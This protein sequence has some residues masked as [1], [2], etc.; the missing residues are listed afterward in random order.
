MYLWASLL[1]EPPKKFQRTGGSREEWERAS[2]KAL[3]QF[4]RHELPILVC[5]GE[6]ASK[7]DIE[8]IRFTL[9]AGLPASLEEFYRQSG[10]AGHDGKKSSC[11]LFF[12][13]DIVSSGQE[14]V[15]N[16][17]ED[18]ARN[19][20]QLDN[21][22]PG[23]VM[24]KRILSQVVLRLFVPAQIHNIGDKED[25]EI[26]I[27]SFPDGLF[28]INGE[29]KVPPERKQK[30]LEKALYR[31]LL[32]GAI[33]GYERR[34]A[35]FKVSVM[36]SEAPY[37]YKNFRN[38]INRYEL[39]GLAAPNQPNENAS[40][41][42]NAVLRFGCRLIEY[43]Y[44]RIKTR[45][46]DDKAKMLQAAKEGQISIR[47]FQDYLHESMEPS[48]IEARLAALTSE[49]RWSV[50]EEINGLD[51]LLGLLLVCHREQRRKPDDPMLRV[52]AGFCAL[53]FPDTGL[54]HNDFVNGFRDLKSSTSALCR[55]ELARQIVS[56][57]ELLMPSKSGIILESIWQA[58]PSLE[59][60]RL[61]YERSDHSSEMCYSSLFKLVNG[62]LE[63]D[64][65][66]EM[67]RLCYE[68]SGHSSETCYSSLFKLV[69]GLLEA[70]PAEGVYNE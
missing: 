45:R 26:F 40:S 24:E 21:E 27:S 39:E 46:A 43:G 22:F 41:Y 68:R 56:Y 37:I 16:G 52:V 58:D 23:R 31:L 48:E 20:E 54:E 33:V 62:L 59:I 28:L 12:S 14:K 7:L 69:T 44:D 6:I 25:S 64:P 10:R 50:L 29:L 32:I 35:S 13:D 49:S 57:A 55:A 3:L 11:L 70:L 1:L 38:Y 18:G 5:S 17:R 53:A 36:V 67:S 15:W 51:D 65:S 9:H 34:P 8:D 47:K 2:Q 61:C 19:G 63:D 30:L 42:K 4:K 60:S 66:L